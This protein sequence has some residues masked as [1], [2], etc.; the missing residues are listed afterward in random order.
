MEKLILTNL[1]T[2]QLKEL[3]SESTR[4]VF[5]EMNSKKEEK[6]IMNVADAAEFLNLAVQTIYGFTSLN[7]IP[8][9]KRGK[10]LIFNRSDLKEWQQKNS[11]KTMKEMEI[12]YK[13]NIKNKN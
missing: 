11:S 3:I 1:T 10:K 8:Y 4:E 5:N 9:Y 6:E 12:D 7:K 13:N 2:N